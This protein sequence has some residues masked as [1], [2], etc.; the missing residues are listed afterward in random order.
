[1]QAFLWKHLVPA[2]ELQALVF[3]PSREFPPKHVRAAAAV[4][5]KAPVPATVDAKAPVAV[6]DLSAAKPQF[7]QKQVAGRLRQLKIL[8][9]EGLLTDDFY[10]QKVAECE[11]LR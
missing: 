3:N 10:D 2:Q 11:A 9:G 8:Y 5:A 6:A 7:T 4:E 1:M